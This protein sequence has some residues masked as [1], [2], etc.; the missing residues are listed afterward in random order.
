MRK[1]FSFQLLTSVFCALVLVLPTSFSVYAN[2]S[3]YRPTPKELYGLDTKD[4]VIR[5]FISKMTLE[6]KVG[7]L[8]IFGFP[9]K[10]ISSS[11]K[12]RMQESQPGGIIVFSRN[13]DNPNQIA[14]LNHSAHELSLKQSGLPLLIMVDQEGGV[15]SRIKTRPFPPSALAIGTAQNPALAKEAGLATG[16]ILS[17]LGFNMNLAPVVDISDPYTKNFI[18]NRSFGKDPESVKVMGQKFSD[19]LEEANVLAT[20]KHFPGHGGSISDSH[21]ELPI[22][23]SNA[24][25]LRGHDLVPFAHFSKGLFSGAVMVGHISLPNLDPSGLPATFSK[26]IITDVLRDQIGFSGLVIT[27]DIEMNGSKKIKDV[28]ERAVRALEA[29]VDMI[30]V[31]WTRQKQREAFEAVVNAV[32]KQRIS[33]LRINESLRRV[34]DAK[35][36]HHYNETFRERPRVFKTELLKSLNKLKSVANKVTAYNFDKHVYLNPE[37]VGILKPKQKVLIYSG[38][39]R[40]YK[41]FKKSS[42]NPTYFY[43]LSPKSPANIQGSLSKHKNALGVFYVTGTGTSRIL[44]RLPSQIKKQLV[45][46]NCTNP[47]VIEQRNLFLSVIDLNSRNFNAGKWLANTLDSD[48][49]LRKPASRKQKTARKVSRK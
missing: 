9:G 27:D 5:N 20:L 43:P 24:E 22:K 8:F 19:G 11:L 13:I 40:F 49:T 4:E 29:G 15:V 31:A 41:S 17:L 23:L 12:W 10:D 7:Q 39:Y 36:T 42:G 38:D 37:I 28:G 25:E 30:M 2:N 14:K 1:K 26:K 46:V 44:N 32:K 35:L 3:S 6:Q 47:G 21:Y 45:V 16:E 18:G 48:P 33:V 34:L